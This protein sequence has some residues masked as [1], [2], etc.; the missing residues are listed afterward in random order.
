MKQNYVIATG[1]PMYVHIQFI[2]DHNPAGWSLFDNVSYQVASM[3]SC[4]A[5]GAPT[6]A[7]LS[8]HCYRSFYPVTC[9][10]RQHRA[11]S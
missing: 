2:V 1:H 7:K 3:I 11:S 8:P 10:I 4:H 9:G 5:N 6:R